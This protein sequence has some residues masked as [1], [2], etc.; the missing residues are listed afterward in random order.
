MANNSLH[1]PI[2]NPISFIDATKVNLPQYLS[3]PYSDYKFT[4][5]I[6]P[7]EEQVVYAQKWQTTDIMNLQF[8]SNFD[9][10]SITVFK[11]YG[12]ATSASCN[13]TPKRANRDLPG[14]FAYEASIS[15]AGFAPGVYYVQVSRLEQILLISEPI[16]IANIHAGTLYFQYY[17]SRFHE[18]VIFETGIKF[19]FRVE[20][21]LGR[22]VFGSNDSVF[23]D[24]KLNYYTLNSKPHS[25]IMLKVGGT[26]GVPDWV[27]EKLNYIWSCNNVSIDGNQYAKSGESK[28]SLIEEERYPLRSFEMEIRFGKNRGSKIISP[29][30]TTGQRLLVV[31]NISSRV[32]GDVSQNASNNTIRILSNE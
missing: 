14:F 3:R 19:N 16:C 1:I 25:G 11:S 7:G 23:A 32:F 9:S 30:L 17:N 26:F 13:A 22:G 20:G 31:Y 29:E 5:T 10:L 2:L 21:E 15:W 24:Q 12:I 6:L 8:I 18:D 4:E 28:F 27:L